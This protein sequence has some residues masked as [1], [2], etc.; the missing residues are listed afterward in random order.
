MLPEQGDG[1][2]SQRDREPM[3]SS[4]AQRWDARMDTRSEWQSAGSIGQEETIRVHIGRIDVRAVMAPSPA[5]PPQR[6][7]KP[8]PALGL[9]DYLKQRSEGKR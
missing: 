4:Q 9:N 7:T 6:V 2:D 5:S 3:V 8:T 1:S